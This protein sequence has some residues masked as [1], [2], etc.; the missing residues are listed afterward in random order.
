MDNDGLHGTQEKCATKY[1]EAGPHVAYI[2]GFQAGG[3][4]S[5]SAKYSGPDTDGAKILMM[6]GRVTSRYFPE[7]DPAKDLSKETR[8]TLCMFKS[9][10]KPPHLSTIP[11]IGDHVALG[12]LQYVGRGFVSAVDMHDAADFRSYAADTPGHFFAWAIYGSILVAIAGDYRLCIIS[13]DG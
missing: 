13:D 8:F 1:L 12:K 6:S 9:L 10:H 7:C 4:V 3:G 2:E 11:R 5:M